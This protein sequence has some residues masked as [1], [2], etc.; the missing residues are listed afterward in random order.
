M[1]SQQRFG[2]AQVAGKFRDEIVAL[3]L[4]GRKGPTVFDR[5]EHNRPDTTLDSLAK[6]KPAF[7]KDGTITAGNAPGLNSGAAAMVVAERD[8]AERKGCRWR[9]W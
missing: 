6:L 1:R 3:E 4:P 2:A 7:R 9:V 8:F 5:D